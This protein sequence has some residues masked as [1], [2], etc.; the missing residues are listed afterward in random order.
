[1]KRVPCQKEENR[2]GTVERP[3]QH[4]SVVKFYVYAIRFERV[5]EENITRKRSPVLQRKNM[6]YK[7]Q[8]KIN[9]LI[10]DQYCPGVYEN[11]CR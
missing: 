4:R 5:R 8:W 3:V 2:I 9:L 11:G 1:M 10:F 6:K 7:D